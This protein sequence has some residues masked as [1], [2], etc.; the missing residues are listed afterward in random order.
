MRHCRSAQWIAT[1]FLIAGAPGAQAQEEEGVLLTGG[2]GTLKLK[3]TT[4]DATGE[5]TSRGTFTVWENRTLKSGRTIDLDIVILHATGDGARPDPIFMLAGGPGQDATRTIGAFG[6]SYL[7]ELHDLVYISQ[8]GTGGSMRLDCDLLASDDN[9]QAYLDGLWDE[10]TFRACLEELSKHAD[11]TQYST[12]IAMDDLNEARQA[13]GYERINLMGGSYGTRAA[14]VY[15]RR[16]PKTVRCAVLNG[17]APIAFANPLYHAR[18]AQN[19]IDAIF[20]ECASDPACHEAF[21]DLPAKLLHVLQR[22]EAQ[23]V[24]VEVELPFMDGPQTG[25]LTRQAFAGALRTLMYG[26]SRRIPRLLN[27]AFEGDFR[28]F[29]EAGIMS[30]RGIIRQ[31]AFGMLLCVTCAE[32]VDRIEEAMIGPATAGTFYGPDRIYEQKAL[33]EFWPRSILPEGFGEDVSVNVPTLVLSGT[34]DPV[35][36]PRWGADAASHLPN[37]LHVVA[38]GSHGVASGGGPCIRSIIA[39]FLERASVRSL[40]VSCVEGMD[41]GPFEV[42][43]DD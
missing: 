39:E 8:R 43:M 3:T 7:R 14:L 42:E 11:L 5:K 36:G 26:D 27:A 29:A 23:P 28:G 37:S 9:V 38:P 10:A 20:A 24:E 33:C 18:E 16:Y 31:L 6:A 2:A 1:L 4:D 15:M 13:L 25:T 22:L 21:G 35:T 12:P 34:Y 32:D 17:V 40:D 19:A 41:L 30:N